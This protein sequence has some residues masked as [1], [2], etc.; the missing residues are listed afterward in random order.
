MSLNEEIRKRAQKAKEA[1]G[2]EGINLD[3]Y[4][5]EDRPVEK[6]RSTKEIPVDIK[7]SMET[8][9]LEVKESA[10]L[11]YL[12]KGNSP[13]LCISKTTGIDL[14]P[15]QEAIKKFDG[16]DGRLNI[17]DYLWKAVPPDK[18]KYTAEAALRE[19][20]Q[21]Y[22]I[23]VHKGARTTF[24]I[25]S[26]LFI[27]LPGMKQVVHNIIIAEEDSQIDLITGCTAHRGVKK[28]LHLGVSEFYLKKN[29]KVSFTMVHNWSEETAVRPR[30]GI[31]LDDN[32]KFSNFYVVMSEVKDLQTNPVIQLNGENS[33]YWG[34]TLIYGKG[35]SLFDTGSTCF[36]RGKGSN[37][38]ILSR[39]IAID[40]AHIIARGKIVGDGPDVT[41]HVDCSALL[42]SKGAR[43]DSIP[44]IDALNPEVTLSHEASVGKISQ[45]HIEYLMSRG[46]NEKES[47]DLI[48][49]GFLDA[50]TSY[51]PPALAQETK[52]LI[53]AVSEAEMG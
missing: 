52:K 45:D 48:I 24:P 39:V 29:A 11:L 25:Q 3:E 37:A 19:I 12:Q 13:N 51:L 5:F 18:D 6:I 4:S 44:E 47:Q 49:R 35:Q 31:I 36:L 23:Y 34:Q 53:Q 30:T 16:K 32:A 8:V 33:S 7:Q 20:T 38:E 10:D 46:L 28:A 9:G 21:G 27:D 2:K 17:M 26:C 1:G 42:L 41:G 15:I 22:F 40:N 14:M 43:V 50:D